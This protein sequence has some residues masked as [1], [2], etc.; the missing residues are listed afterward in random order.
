MSNQ[1]AEVLDGR[2]ETIPSEIDRQAIRKAPAIK[3]HEWFRLYGVVA[4]NNRLQ[5]IEK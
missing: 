5:G 3:L 2:H 4:V 1:T